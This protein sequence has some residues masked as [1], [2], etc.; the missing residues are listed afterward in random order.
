M[1][2]L[3]IWNFNRFTDPRPIPISDARLLI[4]LIWPSIIGFG[5]AI[6]RS[7]RLRKEIGKAH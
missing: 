3:M 6:V 4:Y 2:A 1:I 5:I 7:I